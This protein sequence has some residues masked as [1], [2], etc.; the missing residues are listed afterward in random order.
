M[1]QRIFL[2]LATVMLSLSSSQ[3]FAKSLNDYLP[4]DVTY[5]P[6][7]PKPAEVLGYE[8]GKLR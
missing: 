8:L 4:D 2:V 6:S 3:A 5:D 7:V 1:L